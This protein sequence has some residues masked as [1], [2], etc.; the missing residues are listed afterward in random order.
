MAEL[1]DLPTIPGYDIPHRLGQGGMGIVYRALR[2]HDN[3]WVAL[4][5]IISTRPDLKQRFRREVT[6]VARLRHP[7]IVELYDTGEH[8]GWPF[9]TMELVTGGNLAEQHAQYAGDVERVLQL[10]EQLARAVHHA[11]EANVVHR[12]LKPSNVLLT[13][14]S[15]PKISDFGLAK[16]LDGTDDALTNTSAILG[17]P[18]YLAPEVA[19][20]EMRDAGPSVDAYA[21]GVILYELLTGQV[22]F[23]GKNQLQILDQI[24]T[25]PPT[26]PSSLHPNLPAGL[27][28]LCLRCLEKEARDRPVSAL[29]LAEDLLAIR[30]GAI[31]RH[32]T[33]VRPPTVV[34]EDV[35]PTV[36]HVPP[37]STQTPPAIPGF[38]VQ[39]CLRM[40]G[41]ARIYRAR[42]TRVGRT[43]TLWVARRDHLDTL[44]VER[45]RIEG[46]V[47]SRL[48]HPN[49]VQLIDL[50]EHDGCLYRVEEQLDGGSLA[51]RLK[52]EPFAERD[53]VAL[54]ATLARAMHYVHHALGELI[55]H[56]DL[57]PG[58]VQ[59]T[60]TGIAKIVSFGLVYAPA[61]GTTRIELPGTVVGTPAYMAPELA[62]GV[63]EDLGPGTDVFGLGGILYALLTSRPPR[64]A[65]NR[66]ADLEHRLLAQPP[67]PPRQVNGQVSRSVEKI[68]LK[69]LEKDPS[70]RYASALELAEELERSQ[71]GWLG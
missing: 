52:R 56:R 10:V 37:P 14:N 11:H 57:K 34:T 44:A 32:V 71:R 61:F 69:A 40:Q 9:F 55:V 63:P 42:Q 49:V 46:E 17:T 70:D 18:A 58:V 20:G 6:A 31:P 41:L 15:D 33:T 39:E 5:Q 27:E 43:V 68:C 30:Q 60:A 23:T 64:G 62:R 67:V 24:R 47:L 13:D 8:G 36:D 12:D 16:C 51:Y 38:E 59:F 26:P 48:Q 50:G 45:F 28:A 35:P 25:R 29:E 21:L 22:P 1:P 7:H 19:R 3:R 65:V 53:A 54:V 4:K 2:L 66:L